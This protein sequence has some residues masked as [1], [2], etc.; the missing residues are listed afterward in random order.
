MS[1]LRWLCLSLLPA[2]HAQAP[3]FEQR[4]RSMVEAYAHPANNGPLGY[5]NIAAKL[6]KD[7]LTGSS[8]FRMKFVP[9]V[10]K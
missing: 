5:A 8:I 2:L 1:R 3:P 10:A 4:A 6:G 7:G 9:E